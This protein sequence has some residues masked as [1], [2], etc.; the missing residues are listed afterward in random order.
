MATGDWTSW[1]WSNKYRNI[2]T[3]NKTISGVSRHLDFYDK[4][5]YEIFKRNEDHDFSEQMRS[6][7][8]V[9]SLKNSQFLYNKFLKAIFGK[10]L[11]DDLGVLSYEKVANFIKNQADIDECDINA[12]YNLAASVDLDSDDFRLNYPFFIKRLMD[13]FSINKSILWGDKDKSA[14]N[15]SDGGNYGI[16]NRGNKIDINGSIYAGTPVLLKTKSLQKYNLIQT[17]NINGNSFYDINILADFLKLGEDWGSY[18]EF[19]EYI[20]TTSNEQVEGVIDWDNP[21][22]TLQ[23]Y[24]SSSEFWFGDEKAMETSFAYELYKGLKLLESS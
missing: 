19:Y 3:L 16:L 21:N 24:N 18:Y 13:I 23:Y 11:H 20:P 9:E 1:K 5:P 15:F 7:T 2:S 22:T 17:G 14:Y 6:V 8:F 10:D 4:N 12:L